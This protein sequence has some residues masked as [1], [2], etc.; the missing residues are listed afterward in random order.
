MMPSI[1]FASLFTQ[2][3]SYRSLTR[4][5]LFAPA[6]T[7]L[8]CSGGSKLQDRFPIA[9]ALSEHEEVPDYYDDSYLRYEDHVYQKRIRTV[10]LHQKGW[11]QGAPII[12]MGE[13]ERLILS[14]DD[15]EGDR[16]EYQ[17]RFIHCDAE[18]EASSLQE[19]QYLIGFFED[20]IVDQRFSFNTQRS[21]THYRLKVPNE[22]MGITRSGNYLL[23]V[24]RDTGEGE[25]EPIITRR[26]MVLAPKTVEIEGSVGRPTKMDRYDSG[27]QV[28]F[29][30]R[31]PDRDIPNPIRSLTV[32]VQQN[33]R[34]DNAVY[35]P[36]VA[37]IRKDQLVMGQ[38]G[39]ATIFQAMNEFRAF[40]TKILTGNAQQVR[41][42]E[43][44]SNGTEHV[45][46]K[47][48]KIRGPKGYYSER[49][50]NGR[51]LIRVRTA[52]EP[53]LSAEYVKVH[54]TL[55][56][57]APLRE[58][59]VHI[60][61]QISDFR[62]LSRFRMHYDRSRSMYRK[63]LLLKQGYHEYLYAYYPDDSEH[64]RFDELEG[65]FYETE[66]DY[67]VLVYYRR[68]GGRTDRLIGVELFNSRKDQQSIRPGGSG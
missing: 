65:N 53:A 48:D 35:D 52:S 15:L 56:R 2:G 5:L 64:A 61:G 60:F 33:G 32:V 36:P 27:H 29:R 6:L 10:R 24:Y 11:E 37:S 68:Q 28:R 49:D 57:T 17:Y 21:Y 38:Q 12:E 41:K 46:L 22:R 40:D 43:R 55:D 31:Y 44:D 42:V 34:W 19:S 54:F 3:S 20:R 14:F 45:F 51:S 39:D 16:K 18:W 62:C 7:L 58:G 26:F 25:I 47:P 30:V 23:Y 67:R 9:G 50:I 1:F 8:G 13:K 66:N 59:N 63:T 4:A